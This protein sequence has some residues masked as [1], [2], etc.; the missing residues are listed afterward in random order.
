MTR[1]LFR[2]VYS[3]LF[4]D[5]DYQQLSPNGRLVFL[6][7]RQCA[8]AGPAAIFRYYV[9]V[10]AQQTGLSARQV[11]A[12]IKELVR[13]EWC[14]ADDA[15]FW[16]RNGLRHD[17]HLRL[18]DPKHRKAVERSVEALP[19]SPLVLTFCDYYEIAR[20]FDAP[21][22]GLPRAIEDLGEKSPPRRE[23]EEGEGV[24]S[25]SSPTPPSSDPFG[26]GQ[27]EPPWG[28]PEALMEL[29]NRLVPPGHP[30]VTRL[31]AARRQK[32]QV[33][34]AQFPER[35]FWTGVFTAIRFSAFLRGER[36]DNGHRGYRADF[37]WLLTK[38][39][40]GTENAVKV[41]EGRYADS[42]D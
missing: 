21:S 17:P 12:A 8:Q 29:Y 3:S 13:A 14:L 16:V 2:G 25:T 37:D 7:A 9:P 15:V 41:E 31:T 42:R 33:Y 18:S 10:L 39:K 6:T 19:H 5:P 11:K 38:G 34:L 27:Q 23:K 36:S 1:G 24:E 28:T 40:D 26:D 32:A 22:K 4:D 20:P 30:R 35:T